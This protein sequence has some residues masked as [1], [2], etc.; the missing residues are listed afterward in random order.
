MSGG[1][2]GL[3]P[4][5][6]PAHEALPRRGTLRRVKDGERRAVPMPWDYPVAADC[7]QCAREIRRKEM[8]F[9]EWEHVKV[10]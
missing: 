5:E 4:L 1:A 9:V 6:P 8:M 3:C 7:A 10:D 2:A